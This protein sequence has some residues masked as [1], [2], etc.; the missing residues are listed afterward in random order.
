[1]TAIN[2]RCCI[3]TVPVSQSYISKAF[4]N[5][6]LT[7]IFAVLS[8]FVT[9]VRSNVQKDVTTWRERAQKLRKEVRD[10]MTKDE[11]SRRRLLTTDVSASSLSP[12]DVLTRVGQLCRRSC[13][14]CR[15]LLLF[16][17]LKLMRVFYADFIDIICFFLLLFLCRVG[18]LFKTPAVSPRML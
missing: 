2:S 9:E 7:S 3:D 14:F 5:F 11:E 17:L 6:S 18:N 1:M 12:G 15:Q 13:C 8:D 4:T 10:R 16:F